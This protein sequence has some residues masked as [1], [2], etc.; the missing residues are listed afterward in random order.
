VAINR[1]Y[2]RQKNLELKEVRE[3]I[4]DRGNI[5]WTAMMLP[6]HVAML[7]ELKMNEDNKSKPLI[8]EQQLEEMND[9]IRFAI[10]TNN[11]VLVTYYQE[12]DYKVVVGVIERYDPARGCIRIDNDGT[13][14]TIYTEDIIDIKSN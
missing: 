12:Y 13:F 3:I 10:E 9:L 8:D 14:L 7:R 4:R 5:K 1:N 11:S 2:L 6:E